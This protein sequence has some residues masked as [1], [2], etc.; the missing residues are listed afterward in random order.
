MNVKSGAG[1]DWMDHAS[2][3]RK[4]RA[5]DAWNAALRPRPEIDGDRIDQA[6]RDALVDMAAFDQHLIDLAEEIS[7]ASRQ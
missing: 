4:Q 6:R 1:A 2:R 5:I 3:A 7:G